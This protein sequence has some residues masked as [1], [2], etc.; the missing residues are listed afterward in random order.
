MA[1][2]TQNDID[3]LKASIATGVLEVEFNGRR[4]KFQSLM[5]MR[6]L[7]AEMIADVNA[8]AGASNYKLAAVRKG[9]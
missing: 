4:T 5:A 6:S 3:K 8:A 2:W 1:T 9:V 7:L